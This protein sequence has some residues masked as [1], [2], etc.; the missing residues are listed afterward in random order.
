MMM[1]MM[2]MIV[3]HVQVTQ[4][5]KRLVRTV[6]VFSVNDKSFMSCCSK[7]R[8]SRSGLHGQVVCSVPMMDHS[9]REGYTNPEAARTNRK[10]IP[11]QCLIVHSV[12]Q[13][14]QTFK[15]MVRMVIMFIVNDGS[16]ISC[17]SRRPSRGLVRTAS[18]FSVHE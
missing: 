13:V 1:M 14:T 18:A 10:R 16:F 15:R 8:R 12:L 17:R 2:M 4:A 3:Y 11:C 6:S 9:S 7:S 5:L